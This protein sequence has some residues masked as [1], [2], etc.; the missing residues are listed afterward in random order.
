M[1][2]TDIAI[3]RPVFTTMVFL[4]LVTLGLVGYRYMGVDLFPDVTFPVVTVNTSYPG[5]APEEV[6]QLITR[7]VEDAVSGLNG[8][9][10]VL[11]HSNDSHSS[12]IVFFRTDI[13]IMQASSDVRDA[14]SRVRQ[15]LP[16]DAEEP[17]IARFDPAQSPILTYTASSAS[18]SAYET[19][20]LVDDDIKP[21]LEQIPGVANVLVRGGEVREIQ[22][23]LNPLLVEPLGLSADRVAGLL[24]AQNRNIP[25]GRM[26]D[27]LSERS[28]RMVAQFRTVEEVARAPLLSAGGQV[29]HVEDVARVTDGFAERR[30]LTRVNGVDAVSVGIQRASGENTV[31]VAD[32]VRA[33][34]DRLYPDLPPD[35]R[36]VNIV[37]QSVFINE[38]AATVKEHI[39]VGGL[40]AVLVIFF[41]MLNARATLITAISLPTAIITTFFVMYL[42]GF[43]INMMTLLAM[44]LAIGLLIDDAVVVRENIFRHLEMG[45]HPLKAASEG[46]KE[47]ALAVLATTA[48][49]LAVFVPVAFMDGMVGMFFKEFGITMAAAVTVSTLV[50]F[51]LD[52]MLSA[53]L[54]RPHPEF[55][56]EP[57]HR[58]TKRIRAA[59]LE[60]DASYRR[61]LAWTLG[62]KKTVMATALLATAS[63]CG[64][65]SIMGSEFVPPEDR[66]Q[67]NV[68][69]E[70]PAW[71]SLAE[72]ERTVAQVEAI[73][74]EIPEV[75]DVY[76]VVGA[77]SDSGTVSI[78]NMAFLRVLATDKSERRRGIEELKNDLRSQLALIPGLDF[79]ISD[80]DFV[81]GATEAPIIVNIQG[82]DYQELQ[83]IT[84]EFI[85][86]ARGVPGIVDITNS[87]SP[88]RP[89]YQVVIDR[90]KASDLGVHVAQ[91]G[92]ALRAAMDGDVTNK[93]RMGEDE[94]DIRVR[95]DPAHVRS[96]GFLPSLALLSDQGQTVY[97]SQIAEVVSASGP[98]TIE[99]EN[100]RRQISLGIY[101]SGRSLG[102]VVSDLQRAGADVEI[103]PGY[104]ITYGGMAEEMESS[105]ESLVLALILAIA[106]IYFVLA[107][108]FE[109]FVHPFTIMTA[110]PLGMAGAFV[111]LFLTGFEVSM[112]VMIGMILLMGLATKNSILLVDYTN[113][114][115]R[116]DGMDM[117][118][119]LLE[120]C[121]TRLR[122]ILMTSA[123]IILGML[124]TAVLQGPGSEFRQPMAVAVI[125]GVITST[126][127]T[128]VVVPIIY[129]WFDRFTIK[130]KAAAPE[131][132]D[133]LG[134][135]HR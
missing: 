80:P 99:R 48:T 13:D 92:M 3:Q 83:R 9:D 135:E 19:R 102:E 35:L 70:L 74:A 79:A 65:M 34:L 98:S 27:P 81:E 42:L 112:P 72:T 4:A 6:E 107:S 11:S 23:D 104:R 133:A 84:G 25:A 78:A 129:T 122:P 89:E 52:P 55:G 56:F 32:A 67:F 41:F 119:A 59:Y 108:Q 110:L 61:L 125:G 5:A 2:I 96:D 101:L 68:T 29:I 94:F 87:F 62:H 131:K 69:L 53:R 51:T 97:L 77:S 114:L 86:A 117:E 17:V 82:Q 127:L 14:V 121:P 73:L 33:A 130:E 105:F 46:T 44:T 71:S 21:V 49:I 106:F 12:V 26:N 24:A 118:D 60:L 88:G 93:L 63:S 58:L 30:I 36:M 85:A 120:A 134:L 50:A 76:A 132:L 10:R 66:G 20:R 1:H 57:R 116:R 15:N 37:D 91:A 28:V 43:T 100:R 16:A 18:L 64:L 128:L 38:N 103:P 31:E 95:I 8:L 111:L 22:V 54:I 45:K 123:A 75:N 90:E 109:S 47:I 126:L 113:Q 7:T 115:R 39:F 40:M 124:P